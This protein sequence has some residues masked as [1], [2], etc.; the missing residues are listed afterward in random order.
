[1]SS[2]SLQEII[3][4][5]NV[6]MI[7]NYT[8]ISASVLWLFD[9]VQT[10]PLELRS[11]WSK[12]LS[13]MSIIFILNRYLFLFSVMSSIAINMP[14]SSGDIICR[15]LYNIDNIVPVVTT[16]ST[17]VLFTLRVY[18]LY[19]E[20]IW[21]LVVASAFIIT[22]LALDIWNIVFDHGISTQGSQYESLSR[23]TLFIEDSAANITTIA[24]AIVAAIEAVFQIMSFP[25]LDVQLST[26]DT[27]F[28]SIVAP[29]FVV[30]PNLLINRLVLNL[31]VFG[32]NSTQSTTAD[33][34]D[35]VFAHNNVIGNIGAPVDSG[36]DECDLDED[37]AFYGIE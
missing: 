15:N 37:E 3:F 28:D 9:F 18:A 5:D 10:F 13:G 33:L 27:A 11:I 12:R 19:A 8:T 31:R 14:G 22:R 16:I 36:Q 24:A 21:I 17:N 30:L 2:G 35:P 1:M 32:G 25:K 6:W 20:N 34:S 4:S 26:V 23:C 29:Y 7:A